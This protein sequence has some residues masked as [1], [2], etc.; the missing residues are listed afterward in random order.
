MSDLSEKDLTDRLI[1]KDFGRYGKG[2]PK[3]YKSLVT[4]NEY[5]Y[6]TYTNHGHGG[7]YR[8]YNDLPKEEYPYTIIYE[9]NKPTWMK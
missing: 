7:V 4:G 1:G 5:D 6:H 2:L 9:V 3:L 8:G